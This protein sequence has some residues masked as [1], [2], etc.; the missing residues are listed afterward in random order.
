M[1]TLIGIF[2]ESIIRKLLGMKVFEIMYI[3]STKSL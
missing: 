1:N 3:S 2:Y